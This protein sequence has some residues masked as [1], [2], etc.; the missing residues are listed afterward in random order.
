MLMN[1]S[2]RCKVV[3]VIPMRI[4]APFALIFNF[5]PQLFQYFSQHMNNP[6]F[7]LGVTNLLKG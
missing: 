3:T 1:W 5:V 6:F 7:S 2:A 4:N